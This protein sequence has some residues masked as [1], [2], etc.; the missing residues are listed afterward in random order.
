MF[1]S[2][3]PRWGEDPRNSYDADP[4]DRDQD[5]GQSPIDVTD[6]RERG[7]RYE[8]EIERDHG[9]DVRDRDPDDPRDVLLDDLDLPRGLE[10]EVV[11]DRDQTCELNGEDSRTLATVGAF[12]VVP[13]G[14]LRDDA[15]DPRSDSLDHLRHEGLL[16]TMPLDERDRGVVLTDRGRELLDMHR[17]DRDDEGGDRYGDR[18]NRRELTHDASVYD[19]YRHAASELRDRGA[20]VRDV[21]MERELK[22]EYQEFLQARNRDRS[23][24]DGRPDRDAREIEQWAREHE[25][26]Y[27]DER[28]HFPDVRIEYELEGRHHHM[29][30]EVVTEHYR[31]AHA[32]SRASCGFTCYASRGKGGGGRLGGLAEEFI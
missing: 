29:D 2:S 10:R 13:E 5:N 32:A 20:D 1:D 24:S 14:D 19:A 9:W 26:P 6:S 23:D 11:W 30:I 4:R 3:D 18:V 15:I 28:V 8:R 22:R 12:R 27:F 16:D 31:G 7:D 21:V 17:R 25:L